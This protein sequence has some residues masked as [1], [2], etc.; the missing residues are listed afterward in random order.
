M[1]FKDFLTNE[2]KYYL[3]QKSGDLLTAAQSLGEDAP[4]LGN[5]ALIRATQGMINQIRLIVHGR[6]DDEDLKY[7]KTLQKIGVA[8]CKAID[9]KEDMATVI[10]SVQ[11]ELEDMTGEMEVPVNSVG[12]EDEEQDNAN[13]PL[14]AGTDIGA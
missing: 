7:L 2:N 6:W 5:R 4:N 10:S 1:R 11:S 9:D 14:S 13:E 8:L 3:A 12:S